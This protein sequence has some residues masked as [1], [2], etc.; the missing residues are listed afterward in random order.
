MNLYFG[1]F[2]PPPEGNSDSVCKS[3]MAASFD[4]LS[5]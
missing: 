1:G 5:N 2:P 3:V 4:N